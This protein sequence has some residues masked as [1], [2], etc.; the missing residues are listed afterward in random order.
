[1]TTSVSESASGRQPRRRT[2]RSAPSRPPTRRDSRRPAE[3][4]LRAAAHRARERQPPYWFARRLLLVLSGQCP[5]HT[6]LGYATDETYER[7]GALAPAAP[8]RPRG[9]D[10]TA[11]AVLEARGTQIRPG[12]IEAFA[13]IA[14]GHRQRAMAFR[15]E[16]GHNRWRC[17][18]LELDLAP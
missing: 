13:R 7:L 5:V 12:V 11:P 4:A 18:A 17:T 6:L 8:L 16:H 3:S 1:M 10:R 9:T 15:L 14:T 2:P